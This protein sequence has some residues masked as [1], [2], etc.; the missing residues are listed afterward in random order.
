MQ[1]IWLGKKQDEVINDPSLEKSWYKLGASV[2]TSR[3]ALR[4]WLY[5]RW[6]REPTCTHL[7]LRGDLGF[8][9]VAK[10]ICP[11]YCSW[12]EPTERQGGGWT[13]IPTVSFSKGP[14]KNVRGLYFWKTKLL[15]AVGNSGR[16]PAVNREL[17]RI[18]KTE[19]S[20]N[21]TERENKA[22]K[23]QPKMPEIEVCSLQGALQLS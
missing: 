16:M 10:N 23:N 20:W 14:V 19:S 2:R 22:K 21:L 8:G 7:H 3:G 15:T 1:S 9:L 11:S 12:R 17:W 13:S 5:W 18:P 4:V 6:R